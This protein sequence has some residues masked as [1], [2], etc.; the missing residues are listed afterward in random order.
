MLP[1][2]NLILAFGRDVVNDG[3]CRKNSNAIWKNCGIQTEFRPLSRANSVEAIFDEAMNT[4]QETIHSD[5]CA[6][7]LYDPDGWSVQKPGTTLAGIPA[8]G[9]GHSP[10][11]RETRNAEPVFVADT[12]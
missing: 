6:I 5:R 3:S 12:G 10:W 8:G 9:G 4:L 7:L 1:D 2:G 11:T